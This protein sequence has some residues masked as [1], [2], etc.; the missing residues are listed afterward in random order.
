MRQLELF[1]KEKLWKRCFPPI[2]ALTDK[3]RERKEKKF[4]PL[5]KE[6]L[7]WERKAVE[8]EKEGDQ[9]ANEPISI[10]APVGDKK[11]QRE[12]NKK[13]ENRDCRAWLKYY[14]AQKAYEQAKSFVN[15]STPDRKKITAEYEEGHER[16]Q[17]KME[18]HHSRP[19]R[20][21]SETTEDDDYD[22]TL[23][24]NPALWGGGGV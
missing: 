1:P 24:N 8:N 16:C 7:E 21:R 12:W 5:E 23:F 14:E 2:A 19:P 10:T 3:L 6:R 4:A 18:R 11:W 15:R 13:Y 17:R 9:I 20:S 22:F